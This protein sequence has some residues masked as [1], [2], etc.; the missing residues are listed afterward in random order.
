MEKKASFIE[1]ED[2]IERRRYNY[3][4]ESMAEI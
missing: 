2:N 4:G 1:R 3:L